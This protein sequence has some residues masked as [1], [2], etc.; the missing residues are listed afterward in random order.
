MLACACVHLT[1]LKKVPSLQLEML[2]WNNATKNALLTKMCLGT[3]QRGIYQN[4][5]K[6]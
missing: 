1:F 4:L 2:F 3:Y 5:N 6:N